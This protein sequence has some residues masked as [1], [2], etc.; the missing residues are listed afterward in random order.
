[1]PCVKEE[2]SLRKEE[3]HPSTKRLNDLINSRH[4]SID[5]RGLG[6]IDECTTPSSGKT[7]FI[8]PSEDVSSSKIDHKLK[9]QCTYC[10]KMGHI[11][12]RCY[13]RMLGNF[14]RKL[15]NLMNE[16]FAIG[17]RLMQGKK[18]MAKRDTNF[19]LQTSSSNEETKVTRVK[20]VWLKKND[21]KCVI[22]HTVLGK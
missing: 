10:T 20:K 19:P 4:K 9:F 2:L 12:Y 8:K 17:N 22:E 15:R 11:A 18:N 13:M 5:K 1:M 21:H 6:F 7:T 3:S 14:Q 16:S